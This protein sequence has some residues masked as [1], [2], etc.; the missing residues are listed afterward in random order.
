MKD[1]IFITIF[2]KEFGK[3]ELTKFQWFALKD[4]NVTFHR[5][6]GPAKIWFDG[7]EH[8]YMNGCLHKN[9]GPAIITEH[10]KRWYV[11]GDRHRLDGPAVEFDNG[12]VVYYIN[13]KF[14][15]RKTK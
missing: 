5:E 4:N 3:Q 11:N 7:S 9:D 8:W 6:D 1:K 2:T 10:C 14:I 12:E 13:D 15:K